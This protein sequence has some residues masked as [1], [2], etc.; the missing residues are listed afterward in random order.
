MLLAST[1]V[2]GWINRDKPGNDKTVDFDL[3]LAPM[4]LV[5]AIHASA[6]KIYQDKSTPVEP[7]ITATSAV[8]TNFSQ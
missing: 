7:W 6:S 2:E 4:G 5:P 8:M 1:L 3:K